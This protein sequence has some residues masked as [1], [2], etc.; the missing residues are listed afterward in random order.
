VGAPLQRE[1]VR[2][3]GLGA[4]ARHHARRL[5]LNDL[6]EDGLQR[7][8]A[9]LA[10]GRASLGLVGGQVQVRVRVCNRGRGGGA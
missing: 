7:R 3:V 6:A 9:L 4:F 10:E 2:R 8:D 1:V 5:A